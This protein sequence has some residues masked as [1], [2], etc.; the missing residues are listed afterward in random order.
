MEETIRQQREHGKERELKT[1]EEIERPTF[2]G[3]GTVTN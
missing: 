3:L 1:R 2:Y